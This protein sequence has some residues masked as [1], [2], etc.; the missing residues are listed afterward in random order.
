MEASSKPLRILTLAN[1]E[2][3]EGC[4]FARVITP[5]CALQ[6]DGLVEFTFVHLRP[7]N[8]ATL[9]H[10]MRELRHWDLIWISRPRH[11][12]M[13]AIIREARRRAK[14]VLIDIDDWL[15]DVPT[16]HPHAAYFRARPRQ[17][18]VR[19]ALRTATGITASTPTI[20]ERCRAL[21]LRTHVLPNAVDCSQFTRQPRSEGPITI[22]FCGTPTHDKDV[23]LVA[24]PLRTLLHNRL[25]HVR[26]VSV[27][28][29]IPELQGLPG[30]THHDFVPAPEY[31]LLISN[32]C[33][34][35]GL[36]PLQDTPFNRAKSD[37]KYLEY[38]ASGAVTVASAVAPYQ[39][40]IRDDRGI[41][42]RTTT[43]EE[44]SAALVRLIRDAPLRQRLAAR[45]YEWVRSERSIQATASTWYTT[46]QG[47][48]AGH[49]ES[50]GTWPP[51]DRRFERALA[52]MAL[53]QLPYDARQLRH[54][55]IHRAR[56]EVDWRWHRT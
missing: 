26:I 13:L 43:P 54:L 38:S 51:D 33:V 45:A 18:T 52:N 31:P 8:I 53:R 40:S 17:E 29:S 24:L 20:A 30:Y 15:L 19:L 47:Y 21:G 11:Y 37:I 32:L 49:N 2:A 48:C 56:T 12:V 6:K 35:I 27:G 46:F 36:A 34:D 50:S 39:S 7:W 22:A 14:P 3:S 44:W 5:L 4:T 23:S 9:R 41:L 28:C 55:L 10:V 42:V 1:S 16:E 25:D